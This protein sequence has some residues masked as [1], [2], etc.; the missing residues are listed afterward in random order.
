MPKNAKTCIIKKLEL[1]AILHGVIRV[2]G[3]VTCLNWSSTECII[4]SINR[5]DTI[6]LDISKKP[7]GMIEDKKNHLLSY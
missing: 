6:L 1:A 2:L 5:S 4:R 3:I 7:E